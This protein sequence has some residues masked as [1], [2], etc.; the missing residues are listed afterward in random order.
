[1]TDLTPEQMLARI[2]ELETEKTALKTKNSE[3]IDREKVAKTKAEEAESAREEAAE[4]A[5]RDAKDVEAI[6]KRLTAKFQKDID[7]LTAERDTLATDLRV[8]RVDNEITKS[9]SESN[10]RPEVGEALTALL[11]SKVQYNEGVATIDGQ[12]IF[13]FTGAYL[14][15]EAG[16]FFRRPAD[17]SGGGA[18][19]N[20][21]KSVNGRLTKRPTTPAEFDILDAMPAA[22]RNAFLDSINAPDLKV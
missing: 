18:V 13:E 16:A 12:S 7:K 20:T 5:E 15:S 17:N 2:A 14:G 6:E 1:M 11:K 22:E 10:V 19:G 8:I 3:L 9:L 4:R 21:Q